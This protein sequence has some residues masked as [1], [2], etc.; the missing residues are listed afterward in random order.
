MA[1]H[2]L[3]ISGRRGRVTALVRRGHS[4]GAAVLAAALPLIFLHIE[5]QPGAAIGLGSTAVGVEISDVAILAVGI[6]ALLTGIR[7]GF[8]PLRPGLPV[9][10]AAAG[11]FAW[12]FA[13]TAYPLLWD[14]RYGWLVNAVTAA[15]FAEYAVIAPAVPL[16]VRRLEDVRLLFATLTIWSAAATLVAL[17]QFFGVSIFDAWAPGRRQP[18][19]VGHHD[20]AALSGATLLVAV[21]A[22]ALPRLPLAKPSVAAIAAVSGSLG[23]ILAGAVAAVVGLFLAAPAAVLVARRRSGISAG[24]VAVIAALVAAV[25]VGIFAL[26]GRDFDQF[27]RFLGVRVTERETRENIQTYAQ[28][29]LLAYIG[30]RIFL[31]HPVVGVGWQGSTEEQNFVPYLADARAKFPN[32]PAQAFP[33]PS[34]PYGVQNA[35]L[36]TLADLGVVG[37]AWLV[38]LFASVLLVGVRAALRAPPAAAEAAVV[39][40]LWLLLALGLWNAQ[41]LVAGIPLDAVTWLAFGLAVAGAAAIAGSSRTPETR[42]P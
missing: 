33:S 17:V 38:A 37:F 29:T 36:Q 40:L 30:G 42:V 20:L 28:R 35:Y 31:D 16:L 34:R 26:R 12:I 14:D 7:R 39:G 10:I 22:I 32:Q 21:A 25:S 9:W 1:T 2:P 8:A 3:L 23:L 19:F 4:P 24:R 41:G 15:K 6:A 18:S 11:L 27:L 13:A 5:Y